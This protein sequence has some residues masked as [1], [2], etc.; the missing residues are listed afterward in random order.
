MVTGS[1]QGRICLSPN[2]PQVPRLQM[3]VVFTCCLTIQN[4]ETGEMLWWPRAVTITSGV[5]SLSSNG[6]GITFLPSEVKE[7]GRPFYL[8][9]E[10]NP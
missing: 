9:R 8:Q 1:T 4:E 7:P 10:G 3:S 2:P 6:K 5:S